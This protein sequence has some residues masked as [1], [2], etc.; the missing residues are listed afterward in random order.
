VRVILF[1]LL[2]AAIPTAAYYAIRWYA[3]DNWIV[4]VQ[5]GQIVIQQGRQ[6]GVL[7][8]H[9]KIVDHTHTATSQLLA[10]DVSQIRGGVQEPSLVAAKR[11]VTNLHNQY[12]SA[13]EAKAQATT[14]T[15][16]TTTLPGG[17]P[18]PPTTGTT[19]VTGT[20]ATTA[21]TTPPPATAATTTAVTT[22]VPTTTIPTTTAT[23]AATAATAAAGAAGATAT[24][25]TTATTTP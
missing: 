3:Y 25:P 6:G 10:T 1:V 11:Y 8:F 16:T 9:P 20:T 23:T 18:P 14:T 13:Q 2:V 12:V 17:S 7:W 4:S 21:V 15:T 24:T 19:A 22:A 5:K